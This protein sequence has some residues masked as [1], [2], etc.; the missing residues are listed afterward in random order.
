MMWPASSSGMEM[1][2]AIFSMGVACEVVV[3][4]IWIEGIVVVDDVVGAVDIFLL[5]A[6]A[7]E[8]EPALGPGA[9]EGGRSSGRRGG[10]R[11]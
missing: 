8:A 5:E 10:F 1:E 3:E 6:L 11:L 9:E 7:L 2:T 4:Q